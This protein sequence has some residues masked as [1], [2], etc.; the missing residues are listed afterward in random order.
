MADEKGGTVTT[1]YCGTADA[2]VPLDGDF[3]R[4]CSGPAADGDG[5][6]S[7]PTPELL[8]RL[9]YVSTPEVGD[10]AGLKEEK[11]DD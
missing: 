7:E 11:E 2:L 9:G 6:H 5:V 4:A 3:C 8:K 1:L 10:A